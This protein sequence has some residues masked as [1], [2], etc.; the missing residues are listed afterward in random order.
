MSSDDR[1]KHLHRI[2]SDLSCMYTVTDNVDESGAREIWVHSAKS[3][4]RD[5][6][7]PFSLIDEHVK[8]DVSTHIMHSIVGFNIPDVKCYMSWVGNRTQRTV[9][10]VWLRMIIGENIDNMVGNAMELLIEINETTN[11][12]HFA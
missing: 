12:W 3:S 5:Q 1:I 9:Q 10:S 4:E 8:F 7:Y 11:M 2:V 6:W